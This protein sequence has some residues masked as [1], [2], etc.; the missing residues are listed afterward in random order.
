MATQKRF[1]FSII[2]EDGRYR[3]QCNETK[4]LVT[5]KISSLRKAD[6]IMKEHI[7]NA[8]AKERFS[9]GMPKDEIVR[10]V[11]LFGGRLR[12]R[13][14]PWSLEEARLVASI[15]ESRGEMYNKNPKL[16]I[17][18]Y[19]KG[20]LDLICTHMKPSRKKNKV[21]YGV[22]NPNKALSDMFGCKNYHDFLQGTSG[23]ALR[24][25][26][27]DTL[28]LFENRDDFNYIKGVIK[29]LADDAALKFAEDV[30]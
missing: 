21:V 6:R 18:A 27:I 10:L 22:V 30:V 12:P 24:R 2:R 11:K 5:G 1:T 17:S 15:Y 3:I 9:K 8:G 20:W 4:E 26:G 29:Q 19:S 28:E 13:G 16:Y 23:Q 25:Y 7:H 14:K